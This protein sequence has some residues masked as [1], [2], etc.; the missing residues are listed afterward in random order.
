MCCIYDRI[1]NCNKLMIIRRRLSVSRFTKWAFGNRAA[2]AVLTI[3]ILAI[4]VVSY[5]RLPMEFLPSADNPQVTI[6][7]MGHG[8][9][10]MTMESEV[11]IPIERAV[12]GLNG[13]TSVYST[14]GD[15]F[16]KVDLFFEAGY[17]MKLA[18]QD[19]QDA[20]SNVALP[21]SIS[22]PTIS[23]LNTSMIPIANIAVT[24][25][26]GL[27]TENMDFAREE[28]QSL[29]REIKGVSSVDVYG[30]TDSVI[31]V[32]IDDEK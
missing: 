20:L 4:G 31:S 27:T 26:E 28:L 21:Q 12:T 5:F 10:S 3:L 18:K 32:N 14:T 15:G 25:E 17:D 23:Q 7:S 1:L 6:I 19:V 9:D 29:Y 8:T 13:K 30:I 24:F 2:V 22:K 16:S 11:N